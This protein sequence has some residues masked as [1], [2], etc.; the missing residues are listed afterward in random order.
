MV[1]NSYVV[2]AQCV[3]VLKYGTTIL[4][5][6]VTAHVA[7]DCEICPIFK[8][9]IHHDDLLLQLNLMADWIRSLLFVLNV[10]S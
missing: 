7:I 4:A 3:Y 2:Y 10:I 1:R 8:S 9:S 6:S 5:W